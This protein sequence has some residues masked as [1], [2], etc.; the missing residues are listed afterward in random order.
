MKKTFSVL[1]MA[2]LATMLVVSCDD[3]AD[4]QTTTYNIGDTGP[5]GGIVFYDKKSYSD[6]W[7]YLEAGI[8]DLMNEE[9][10][11]RENYTWGPTDVTASL[12]TGEKIGD[13]LKNTEILAGNGISYKAAFTVYQQDLYGNDVKDW[14]IP[15]K[16]ELLALY[17]QSGLENLKSSLTSMNYWSSSEAIE[18]E[19][20]ETTAYRA[21]RVSFSSGN[22]DGA[23]RN[24]NSYIRP[25][26]RF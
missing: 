16:E 13:G 10:T 21:W 11:G 18:K 7:R 2:L 23:D 12:G 3:T 20:G 4:S 8:S 9:L 25:I 5:A 24:N 15:S 17:A 26:R 19:D 22:P 6:G 1:M 14:F